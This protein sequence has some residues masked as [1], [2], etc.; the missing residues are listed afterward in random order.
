MK[1]FVWLPI[2]LSAFFFSMPAESNAQNKKAKSSFYK[3]SF[4]SLDGRKINFSKFQGK[5]VLIVNTASQCGY[6]PQYT[7]LQTLSDQYR[8]KLVV[9]GFPSNN[10][11]SQEPGS[12]EEIAES[13]QKNYGITFLIMQ[14]SDV[15]GDNKNIIYQWLTDKSKNGWN[16]EEPNWNFCKYLIG[17]D[18]TLKKFYLSKVKPLSKEITDVINQ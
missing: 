13:C 2:C 8:D 15:K 18:G 9:I 3:L 6:T 7:D 14:K 16:E 4:T 17:K 1:P 11:G 10:F 5:Y 12:N